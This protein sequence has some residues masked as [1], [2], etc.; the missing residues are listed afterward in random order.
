M[1]SEYVAVGTPFTRTP[2]YCAGVLAG[3]S[4]SCSGKVSGSFPEGL[5]SP[6]STAA[7][8]LPSSSPGYQACRIAGTLLA[9]GMRIAVPLFITTMV[10]GL[11]ATIDSTQES[12]VPLRE[13]G[14][15]APSV[16]LSPTITMA[17]SAACAAETAEE[18][19]LPSL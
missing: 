11:A 3:R 4:A 17:T 16:S 10:L 8:A 9:Q 2:G 15:S 14:L 1:P 12:W 19:T 13:M 5:T 18:I 6:K 7:T